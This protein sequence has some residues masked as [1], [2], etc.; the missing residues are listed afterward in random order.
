LTADSWQESPHNRWAYHH[1]D[2]VLRTRPIPRG[3]GPVLELTHGAPLDIPGPGDGELEASRTDGLL[4][5]HGRAIRFERYLN[6][7]RPDSRHL[8]QSVSKS[9]TSA[10]LGQYVA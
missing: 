8:L 2:E 10:V 6:G 4:V 9:M 3:D 7:M 1:I 5:L